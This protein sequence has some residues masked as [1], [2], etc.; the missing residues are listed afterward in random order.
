MACVCGRPQWGHVLHDVRTIWCPEHRAR[1][2]RPWGETLMGEVVSVFAV[3]WGRGPR[4][5]HRKLYPS[6]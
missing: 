2:G 3:P 6:E 1:A 4:L 5:Q